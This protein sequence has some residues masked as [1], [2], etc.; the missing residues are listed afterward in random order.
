[1]PG[2][3]AASDLPKTNI[4]GLQFEL[5]EV[6]I[7]VLE[8]FTRILERIDTRSAMLDVSID[9]LLKVNKSLMP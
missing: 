9:D 8:A 5:S 3:S 7:G 1:M 4:D 6:R 2:T